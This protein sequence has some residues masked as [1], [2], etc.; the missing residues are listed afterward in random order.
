VDACND[1]TAS[2]TTLILCFILREEKTKVNGASGA[3]ACYNR[4]KFR[5]FYFSESFGNG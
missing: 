4:L 3:S 1:P 5:E 2:N